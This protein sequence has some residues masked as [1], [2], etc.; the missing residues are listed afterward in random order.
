[1]EA[2]KL[3]IVFMGTPEFAAYT[4]ET[5][6]ANGYNI[7]GVITTP[8]KPSGRGKKIHVSA[9]KL[10]AV[11]HHLNL[12]QPE[13]LKDENFITKL[14]QLQADI[15]IVVAFRMLP[16]IVWSLP[17]YGTINLHASLL[18]QYRGA[19]PIN[20]AIINGE[21]ITGV[22]TFFIND[23]IDTG[24]ILFDDEVEIL[25]SD[26][27]GD[28]HNKLMKG[29]ADLLLKTMNAISANSIHPIQ[30]ETRQ[31][32]I[33]ALKTAPKIF[34]NDC[35]ITWTKSAQAIYN[36]IR[37]LSPYP[38]AYTELVSPSSDKYSI[39][40]FKG[41]V[42][43]HET[44]EIPGSIHTDGKTFLEVA[45]FDGWISIDHLQLMGKKSMEVDQFLRGFPINDEWKTF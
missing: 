27:F 24:N 9:V 41:H 33:E 1:M 31:I 14:N 5:L 20:W 35:K 30:Q 39:K 12:L 43:S 34:K 8:D 16:E 11:Q 36:F 18:P 17:K 15:Q 28:L 6:Y 19:A 37:G 2:K 38:A 7:V 45:C 3:R 29:G 22:T 10:F 25:P 13:N 4:L 21:T 32:N 23:K 44:Y 40:I 26:T 42:V